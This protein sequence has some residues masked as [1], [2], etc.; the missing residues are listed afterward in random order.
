[1]GKVDRDLRARSRLRGEMGAFESRESLHKRHT[2]LLP[3][4]IAPGGRDPPRGP[5][6]AIHLAA[7]LRS[8]RQRLGLQQSSAAFPV[9][10]GKR[11]GCG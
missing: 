3:A 10:V 5:E 8:A 6:V 9:P 1:M 4:S 2:F 7:R 11:N